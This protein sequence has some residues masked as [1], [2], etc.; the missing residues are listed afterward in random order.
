MASAAAEIEEI[1]E[2][3]PPPELPLQILQVVR[4]AHTQHGLR[5]GDYSRYRSTPSPLRSARIHIVYDT[6]GNSV[7]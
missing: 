4:S 7:D 6:D 2:A 1:V 5:H 3:S